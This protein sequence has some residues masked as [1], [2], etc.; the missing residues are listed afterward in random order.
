M[1]ATLWC[2]CSQPIVRPGTPTT[3][4]TDRCHWCGGQYFTERLTPEQRKEM[5]DYSAR[6]LPPEAP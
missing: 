2:Q 5:T 1:S 4:Y 3:A 6:A